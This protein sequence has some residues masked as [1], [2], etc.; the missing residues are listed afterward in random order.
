MIVKLEGNLEKVSEKLKEVNKLNKYENNHITLRKKEEKVIVKLIETGEEI[1]E[2]VEEKL[3]NLF[4]VREEFVG[5]LDIKEKEIRVVTSVRLHGHTGYSLLDGMIKIPDLVKKT[6]YSCAITDHGVLYGVLDFYKKM[7]EQ[8]KKAIIGFEAY[9]KSINNEDTKNHLVLLAKNEIGYQNIVKLCSKAQQNYGGKYPQRPQVSYEDLRN[10]SE[11]VICLTACLGGELP[12]AI[13][14]GNKVLAKEIVKELKSIFKD[15]FY[16]EI[17]RHSIEE[18][19]N[20]ITEDEVNNELIALGKEFNVKI[21][22]T[23]DAHYVNKEDSEIHEAHLCNQTKTKITDVNRYKFPG[24]DYHIH[25]CEEMEE[26]F[27]DIPEALIN[28]LEVMDKCNFDFKFGEYKLPPFEK[29][30]GYSDSEY[31]RKIVW[32]GFNERFPVG[33]KENSS[34]EYIDRIEYELEVICN[35]GYPSYFLIVWDFMKYCRENNIGTGPG[36]G[37]ACGSLVAYVLYITNLDPIPYNLLFERFLNPDRVSMPDFKKVELIR[38]G[39]C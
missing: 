30:E 23:D 26:K 4:K 13:Y 36:R 14:N 11:G 22:A 1:L 6:R 29:P 34:K 18:I 38:N 3:D 2:I 31:L 10:N 35:M 19:R 9:C 17:Q 5:V 16:I 8:H 15:D 37:S 12:R 33:T 39:E 25:T 28:T 7:K 27:K 24:T 21:V 20:G 32:E